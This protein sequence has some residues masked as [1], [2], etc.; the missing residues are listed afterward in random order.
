MGDNGSIIK[1]NIN[2][3][4]IEVPV[5]F[6]YK[7]NEGMNSWFIGAGPY[8]AA[9]INSKVRAKADDETY[10]E[11]IKFGKKEDDDVREFDAGVNILAG[12]R[13]NN[14]LFVSVN[15]TRGL[16]NIHPLRGEDYQKVHN[17]LFGLKLGY[18]FKGL[19][20]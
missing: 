15:Y 10:S 3:N 2:L 13:W 11:P 18:F 20:D 7:A 4:Y 5:N 1:G 12:Y 16:Y 17:H 14:G 9:G 19:K 8:I 6:L